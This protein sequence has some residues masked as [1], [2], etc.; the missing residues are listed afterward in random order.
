MD[1]SRDINIVESRSSH[2]YIASYVCTYKNFYTA[3]IVP[4]ICMYQKQISIS[5]QQQELG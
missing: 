4:H 2:S 3:V 5:E 1:A